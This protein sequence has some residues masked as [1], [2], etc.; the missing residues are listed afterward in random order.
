M[1]QNK[2]DNSEIR[3]SAKNE[4]EARTFGAQ[5]ELRAIGDDST[6]AP[7]ISGYAAVFEQESTGLW[8]TEVIMRGAF[9]ESDFSGCKAVFN[10]DENIILGSVSGGT[11]KLEVDERGLKYEITPPDTAYVRD[12]VIAPMRRGDLDKS[13]FRFV[14]D[15]NQ[16]NADTWSWDAV[17]D[18]AV[19]KINKIAR[20]MDV[21][22]V[23]FPA[24]DAADSTVRKAGECSELREQAEKAEQQD[25]E[26]RNSSVIIY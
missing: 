8:F 18:V 17:N 1:K 11:L 21:S 9:D 10:H 12:M 14:M 3:K 2:G 19:R 23:L 26:A 7:V 5:I 4:I 15:Y 6:T 25:K 20:V 16:E 13:S 24:Y 22:P